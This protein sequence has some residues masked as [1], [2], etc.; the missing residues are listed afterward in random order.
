MIKIHKCCENFPKAEQ[1]RV[2]VKNLR[3]RVYRPSIKY[4]GQGRLY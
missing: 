4:S 2:V 3:V 1:G